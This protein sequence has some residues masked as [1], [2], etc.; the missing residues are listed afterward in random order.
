M[1]IYLPNS[2]WI[3]NIDPF[4]NSLDTSNEN[5]LV[6]TSHKRWV[7][8]HPVVLCMIA[9][10]GLFMREKMTSLSNSLSVPKINFEKMTA[11]SKHY[12]ERMK[13]FDFLNLKSEIKITTHE[14]AG[15]FIPLTKIGNSEDL[16]N[17]IR[18]MI[19]LL[20]LK[21]EQAEP[22]K[23]I[24]SELVRN[25]LEHA[26]SDSGAIV[27]AQYYKQSNTIRIGVVDMGVG[28]KET[29]KKYY[30]PKNDLGALLLALTPG[31][32]GTTKKLGG[33]ET[34][35]GAGLFFIKSL[36]KISGDFFMIYSGNAMYKLLKTTKNEKIKLISNP[37]QDH[38]SSKENLPYWDGTVVAIDICL[39]ETIDFNSLLEQI[40]NVYMA[41]KKESNKLKY[42]QPRFI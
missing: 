36:A 37:S 4:I 3:G 2:V 18:E 29:L 7:S 17:F 6:I 20:H 15:R 32:T 23:Y 34:N 14:S 16:D 10:L 24:I 11:K 1:K 9:G 8:V 21:H 28:I 42:K 30:G 27:C 38:H 35:A 25:V 31:I 41:G 12:F 5:I 33:T 19:P 22:I 40:R 13:L 39:N 26:S